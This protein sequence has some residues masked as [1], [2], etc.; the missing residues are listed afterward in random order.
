MCSTPVETD[1]QGYSEEHP[2]AVGICNECK[3]KP[4][5]KPCG[6]VQRSINEFLGKKRPLPSQLSKRFEP[7]TDQQETKKRKAK[8]SQNACPD[9][10]ETKNK[11]VET[12]EKPGPSK[13]NRYSSQKEEMKEKRA[14]VSRKTDETTSKTTPTSHQVKDDEMR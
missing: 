4:E 8:V 6:T 10:Q 7:A 11:K 1:V 5:E 3:T 2:K 9:K 14:D 13:F 12:T